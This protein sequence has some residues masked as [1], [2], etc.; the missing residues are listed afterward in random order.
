MT[1]LDKRKEYLNNL[2]NFNK[3]TSLFV[4][5]RAELKS[6]VSQAIKEYKQDWSEIPPFIDLKLNLDSLRGTQGYEYLDDI[7]FIE[8]DKLIETQSAEEIIES[9]YGDALNSGLSLIDIAD[10]TQDIAM[11]RKPLMSLDL[12]TTGLDMSFTKE[13]GI[14]NK[15]M[16]ITG[17]C[18][19]YIS[20]EG[21]EVTIYLP[22]LNTETDGVPNVDYAYAI[23]LL[24]RVQENFTCIYHNAGFDREVCSL[25]G[26]T[27][28]K[29]GGFFDTQILAKQ[30]DI[31][32]D[33]R[34]QLGLKP[35]SE[36]ILERPYF[37]MSEM[38]AEKV[39]YH[40]LNFTSLNLY[41]MLDSANTLALFRYFVANNPDLFEKLTLHSIDAKALDCTSV[42]NRRGY[43]ADYKYMRG[44][45]EDT[46][47]REIILYETFSDIMEELGVEEE[48]YI[49]KLEA[50]SRELIRIYAENFTA[51]VKKK[52]NL[53]IDIYNDDTALQKFL[54]AVL[55]DLGV[56]IKKKVLK[57]ESVKLTHSMDVNH[58]TY[59]RDHIESIRWMNPTQAELIYDLCEV[60]LN[61]SSVLQNTNSYYKPFIKGL[62][63]D[64]TGYYKLPVA[65]KFMGTITTRY[66][67]KAGKPTT[68]EINQLKTK[69]NYKLKVGAGLSGVNAQGLPSDRYTLIKAKKILNISKFPSSISKPIKV[70]DQEVEES[71]YE[72]LL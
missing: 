24:K 8:Y 52:T 40:N 6:S 45:L 64:D 17:I 71:V 20:E 48:V 67:N 66:S 54:R 60:L 23:D 28:S 3:L 22:T 49:T 27:F 1:N 62:T 55:D 46:K 69:T 56:Q 44:A 42:M 26:V 57:D 41:G 59:I 29:I 32:L 4:R 12:E 10:N 31:M 47:R 34:P 9:F 14:T 2:F 63:V 65:L 33:D 18:L 58:L 7:E 72:S 5:E 70:L 16:Y 38:D 43:P 21:K 25:N 53:T 35:L 50:I 30:T 11:S 68:I 13:A 36:D 19:A 39:G 37:T 15:V 51:F 61:V